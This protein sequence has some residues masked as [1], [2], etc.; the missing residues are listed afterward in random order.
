[1]KLPFGFP[2][3]MVLVAAS[4]FAAADSASFRTPLAPSGSDPDARA[5]L[6]ASLSK[7]QSSL[8]VVASR[9]DPSL[10]CQLLVDGR[11]EGSGVTSRNG[12]V[13]LRFR[14]SD[15][16]GFQRLDFEPRGKSIELRVAGKPVAGAV[17]GSSGEPSR[18]TAS[19]S[20]ELTR[21]LPDPRASASASARYTLTSNG[22]LSFTVSLAGVPVAPVTLLVDGQ[23][24][25]TPLAPNSGGSLVFRFRGPTASAG[26]APLPLDPRGA[27][28]D[29]VQNGAPI[30]TGQMRARALGANFGPRSKVV[31][32]LPSAQSP[33]VGHAE[34]TWTLDQGARRDLEV[35]L[36]EV[37]RGLYDLF[38]N[39]TLRGSFRVDAT[40][41]GNEGEIEF[42]SYDDDELPLDFDPVGAT[43]VVR[44]RAGLVWFS[45]IFDPSILDQRPPAEPASR[46]EEVLASTGTDP[47][48]SGVAE[49]EVDP[50][51]AHEF[52]VEIEDVAVGTYSVRVG[53]VERA[54]LRAVRLG[55]DV[56]GEVEF[57][58]P[59]ER[60]KVLLDFDPRGQLLEVV[61]PDGLVLFRHLFGSGSSPAN[62]PV[63]PLSL[64][65][66][67]IARPGAVGHLVATFEV[68]DEGESELELEARGLP[69][70]T[71][72]VAVGGV[73]RGTLTVVLVGG[74]TRGEIEFDSDPDRSEILLDFPVLG[75]EITVSDLSGVLFSRSLESP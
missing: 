30:F 18:S 73:P 37:P 8:S 1:M 68:D 32:G 41:D 28:L 54:T 61:N 23:P 19:E 9:L 63:A 46:F 59:V 45:G 60:G 3:G 17:L 27:T 6:S 34:V 62:P 21:L 33:P 11:V 29:L 50:E 48:A 67:L 26:F 42:S 2:I 71:Y 55:D 47:D 69:A 52:G 13:T 56:E 35:E 74:R 57:R 64:R 4:P 5:S 38:V 10:P 22:D 12:S 49:Y 53:G 20:A 58:S 14:S 75:R 36:E 16:G 44:D 40:D 7:R 31:L 24:L 66:P 43:L 15:A 39:D 65:Q 25:G 70:G 72:Q 51:G